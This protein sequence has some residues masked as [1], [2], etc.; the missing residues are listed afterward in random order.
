[1]KLF[2]GTA[3]TGIQPGNSLT[4]QNLFAFIND[5][6]ST[7]IVDIRRLVVQDDSTI[8]STGINPLVKLCRLPAKDISGGCVLNKSTFD[9]TQSSNSGVKILASL[10]DGKHGVIKGNFTSP[11]YQQYTNRLR[12]AAEQVIVRDNVLLPNLVENTDFVLRPGEAILATMFTPSGN[13][14][15]Y[16]QNAFWVQCVWEEYYTPTH[17]I[18]GVTRDNSGAILGNCD[19]YLHKFLDGKLIYLGNTTSN[20][21]TGVYEFFRYDNDSNYVITARKVGSPNV[22]DVTDFNIT[23]TII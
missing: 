21:I 3:V 8:V 10:E 2:T 1:M 19:V 6:D 9:T 5:Y 18:S 4:T 20:S 17:K 14:N 15:Q 13:T 16:M 7:V 11:I 23:P 12:S 22:F